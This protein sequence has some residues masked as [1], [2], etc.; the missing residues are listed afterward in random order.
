MR[1]VLLLV[2]LFVAAWLPAAVAAGLPTNST[3]ML[4]R[5][6][7][8]KA[9]STEKPL[10]PPWDPYVKISVKEMQEYLVLHGTQDCC[11]STNITTPITNGKDR[12]K[13]SVVVM[14][15]SDG[16]QI[17]YELVCL[18]EVLNKPC[19]FTDP[20][21]RN[22]TR[23]VQKHSYSYAMVHNEGD[24]HHPRLDYIHVR[25]GCACEVSPKIPKNNK[26]R[27]HHKGNVG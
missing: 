15:T 12:D 22:Q 24:E 16:P 20:R 18:P 3:L 17:F 4:H 19:R 6:A 21:V 23:C 9:R 13:N 11:P 10:V 8:R 1:I 27:H 14:N 7:L 25:M 2:V 26:R 5:R